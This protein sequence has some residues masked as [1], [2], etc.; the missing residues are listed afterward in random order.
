MIFDRRTFL[1]LM[2]TGAL[3]NLIPQIV[4]ADT[5]ASPA[6]NIQLT[7]AITTLIGDLEIGLD[8]R[9][10]NP[11]STEQFR[12]QTH[13][14]ELYPVASS[15]KCFLVLY[16][17]WNTP[18]AEWQFGEDTPIRSVAVFSN[19]VQTGFVLDEVGRRIDYYGN[20]IQKFNDFLLFTL[21]LTNGMYSWNW[22]NTPTQG[23]ADD[24]YAPSS[25]RF[26]QHRGAAV[27]MDNLFTTTEFA[28]FYARL[29]QPDPFPDYPDSQAAVAATLELLSIPA[30]SYESPFERTFGVPYTG[31]DGVL[32]A[33]D[34]AIGRVIND[35]GILPINGTNYVCSFMCAGEGEFLGLNILRE[36]AALL[37]DFESQNQ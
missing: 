5:A 8:L 22:P 2:G 13:A 24:R 10:M 28:D 6:Q 15:F 25:T 35:A 11:D 30:E 12:I 36:I 27:P 34:S 37:E 17:F 19:N 23:Y 3:L 26:V 20:A 7:E 18:Q 9:R 33:S 16:Y 21:G 32:P 1:K 29:L 31:K 4:L 14:D